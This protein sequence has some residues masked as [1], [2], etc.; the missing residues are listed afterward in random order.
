MDTNLAREVEARLETRTARG[1]A[2][3]VSA[4]IGENVIAAG[5]T[6]PPIRVLARDLGLSPGTVAAAWRSLAHAGTIRTNG[7]RGTV[8]AATTPGLVRYRRAL[9][10]SIGFRIDLSTGTPD[11]GLLPDIRP[12]LARLGRSATAGSYLDDPVIP[13]LADALAPTWPTDPTSLAIVDGAMDGLE[14]VARMT[15]RFGDTVVVENPTFPPLL[16]LLEA[17]G[18]RVVG[19]PLDAEGVVPDALAAA[20]V[21]RPRAAFLQTRAQNPTGASMS[22]RRARE[23]AGVLEPSA[24]LVV[25]DDSVGEISTAPPVSLGRHLPGRTVH[26]R[27]YSKSHGPDLRLAAMSGPVD[28]LERLRERR[29]LGQGWTSR[30]LQAVLL[31]LLTRESSRAQVAR[32]RD[33]YARRRRALAEALRLRG[34]EARGDDGLNLWVPVA[35]ETAALVSLAA[36]GIG[37][38]AGAPFVSADPVGD[39][40][41]VTVG[42]VAEGTED[43]ADAL[44]HAATVPTTRGP[45]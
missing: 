18:T 26:I 17:L 31:D 39:H 15:L 25:E 12:S 29:R 5:A 20:L 3:A 44:A 13:G 14:A 43:V 22:P 38:A 8:V 32:A 41:R 24:V 23:L 45:R 4:L 42:L 35:D 2:S 1:L 36:A 6:L 11:P 34:V 10:R 40:L 27:S 19:V 7:R 30:L 9:D 28:I 21:H 16:D 37:A 33:E